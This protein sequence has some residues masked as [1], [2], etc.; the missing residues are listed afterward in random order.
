[1]QHYS[2]RMLDDDMRSMMALDWM[3]REQVSCDWST[4]W[5]ADTLLAAQE[6]PGTLDT[7]LQVAAE[8]LETARRSGRELRFHK[9]KRDILTL[10]AAQLD[11]ARKKSGM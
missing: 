1:M 2:H 3:S 10:A 8:E 6:R 9:E 7:E 4:Q 5:R 11:S